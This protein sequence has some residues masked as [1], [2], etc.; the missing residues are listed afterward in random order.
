MEPFD[1]KL[2]PSGIEDTDGKLSSVLQ[3][4]RPLASFRAY[5]Q[6][7]ADS[8]SNKLREVLETCDTS[9]VEELADHL[10]TLNALDL[11]SY[12]M[13]Q[14]NFR[15]LVVE[16]KR[17]VPKYFLWSVAPG[18][19]LDAFK[20]IEGNK[21]ELRGKLLQSPHGSYAACVLRRPVKLK[22]I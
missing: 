19:R 22:S 13:E 18:E 6:D 2:V 16:R 12:L 11:V 7:R 3:L 8:L 10:P 17:V 9:K 20:T 5:L 1:N 14:L 4:L 21:F 15:D